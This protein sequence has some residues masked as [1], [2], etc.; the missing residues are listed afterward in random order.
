[1]PSKESPI[2]IFDSGVGGLSVWR[3][4]ARLLPCEDILYFADSIHLPYGERSLEEVKA[5]SEAITEFLMEKGAKVVV[6]ACNTASAAALYD[7]RARFPI[8]IVGMEPAVK[9]AVSLTKTGKIG[10]IATK[11]TFQGLLFQ[12]LVERFGQGVEIY[13]Q[14]CP[15]LVEMVEEG[16]LNGREAEEKVKGYL[17]PLLDRGVDVLVLGCTHYPFLR[18]TI[19]RVTGPG[20]TIVDPSEAVARQVKRVL[21]SQGLLKEEG[22][23]HYTFFTSGNPDKF[24]KILQMFTGAEGPVLKAT[25]AEGKV[26]V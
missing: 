12:R 23:G 13:T 21:E 14:A 6:V 7:L 10:V 9:P 18:E 17:E 22:E 16:L 5:F 4:V 19:E 11:A 20:L 8:P 3:E 24:R 1:M 26:K 25:W 15:G 2:G